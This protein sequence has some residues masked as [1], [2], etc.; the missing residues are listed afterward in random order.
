M[1]VSASGDV[2]RLV[3]ANIE[4]GGIEPDNTLA[5][6]ECTI[7]ALTAWKPDVVCVQEMAARRDRLRIRRHLWA[8][9]NALG[10]M[11]PVL[12]SEGGISGNH[13]AILVNPARLR[14]G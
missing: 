5:R 11:I 9:A 12:G 4:E 7:A 8:T 2:I 3:S 6:W 10:G 1:P 13:P 14:R